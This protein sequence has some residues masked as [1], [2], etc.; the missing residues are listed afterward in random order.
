MNAFDIVLV[1]FISCIF[2]GIMVA[3][4]RAM[5]KT[6]L[7]GFKSDGQF[8]RAVHDLYMVFIGYSGPANY[9]ES[10]TTYFL[11]DYYR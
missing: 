9:D 7:F 1:A 5:F 3:A 11:C 10:K 2:F 4:Y 8:R 6:K